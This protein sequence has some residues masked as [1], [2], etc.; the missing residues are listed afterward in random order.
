[1]KNSKILILVLFFTSFSFLSCPSDSA[2]QITYV[3][4][5]NRVVCAG[6]C[7]SADAPECYVRFRKKG[8][9]DDWEKSG[10]PGMDKTPGMEFSCYCDTALAETT[11]ITE[12][13]EEETN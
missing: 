3:E 12:E 2:C 8:S 13:T 11:I 1:M 6:E 7:P 10:Q 9:T 4:G 5:L